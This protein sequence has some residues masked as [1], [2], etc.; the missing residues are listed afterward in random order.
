MNSKVWLYHFL[1]SLLSFFLKLIFAFYDGS[2]I[3]EEP[4]FPHVDFVIKVLSSCLNFLWILPFTSLQRKKQLP[5]ERVEAKLS[6]FCDIPQISPMRR[7]ELASTCVDSSRH[8]PVLMSPQIL[9]WLL[10]NTAKSYFFYPF[11]YLEKMSVEAADYH[12]R[13][14]IL[15]QT[16]WILNLLMLKQLSKS[17]HL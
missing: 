7:M 13:Y 4:A 8:S 9:S 14:V 15:S 17:L 6:I 3:Q 11:T 12:W 10:I 5:S 1:L 2:P 16:A